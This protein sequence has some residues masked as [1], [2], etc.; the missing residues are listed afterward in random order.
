MSAPENLAKYDKARRALH[1][2][3]WELPAEFKENPDSVE[4]RMA[5]SVLKK[6]N[7]RNVHR[8]LWELQ[9]HF[10]YVEE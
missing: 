9:K 3:L 7:V 10:G 5:F 4:P 1:D 8:A 6:S 2:L